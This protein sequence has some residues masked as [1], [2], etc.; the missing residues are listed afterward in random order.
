MV[1]VMVVVVVSWL[2]LWWWG[3]W[4]WWGCGERR[5]VQQ[6]YPISAHY[7]DTPCLFLFLDRYVFIGLEMRHG[8]Q[9]ELKDVVAVTGEKRMRMLV[10]KVEK[11]KEIEINPSVY[12]GLCISRSP[13][14]RSLSVKF[15]HSLFIYLIFLE[16]LKNY[17][18]EKHSN[19]I[20]WKIY[21]ITWSAYKKSCNETKMMRK[22]TNHFFSFRCLQIT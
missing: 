2:W 9:W 4:G 14:C 21:I 12:I 15:S 22:L 17:A 6:A 19:R 8:F 18:L 13:V 10:H 5:L 20:L 11:K 1:F 16:L 7:N 3:W